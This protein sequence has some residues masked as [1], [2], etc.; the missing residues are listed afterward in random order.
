MALKVS[1]VDR[2]NSSKGVVSMRD[3]VGERATLRAILESP[4]KE[5][6]VGGD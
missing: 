2:M 6:F 3:L 4:E 5:I 1:D